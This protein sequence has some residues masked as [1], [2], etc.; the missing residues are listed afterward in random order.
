MMARFHS[1]SKHWW[2]RGLKEE[3]KIVSDDKGSAVE[4][5]KKRLRWEDNEM[6]FDH[7][8]VGVLFYAVTSNEGNVVKELLQELNRE[9]AGKEYSRRLESR[10]CDKGYITL[11]IPGGSTTLMA[12]MMCASPE[13]VSMLLESGAN[14]ERLDVMGNDAFMFAAMFGRTKNLK[15]WLESFK[16]WDLD[17]KNTVAG[18][19]ALSIA[20]Y[21]GANKLETVKLLLNAGASLEYRSFLGSSVLTNAVDNEDS[22]PDVVRVIL[23]NMKS[24]IV[25]YKV[26]A[27]SLKWKVIYFA[28]KVLYRTRMSNSSMMHAIAMWSGASALS[29]AVGRGD[30]E[31]VK[32]LLESGADPYNIENDLGMNAFDICDKYGPFPSVKKVMLKKS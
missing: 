26:K 1:V 28:S 11:G 27:V 4:K 31:I 29:L 3:T 9:F 24:S 16:D 10:L 17:R 22:D 32:I 18:G 14:I 12:A 2:M 20:V 6:W 8:G 25:N 13:V 19:C 23:E 15:Y 5:F 7:S 21:M 30:V